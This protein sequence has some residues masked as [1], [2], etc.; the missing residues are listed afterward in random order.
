MFEVQF[1]RHAGMD[2]S[3]EADT[4]AEAMAIVAEEGHGSYLTVVLD[5]SGREVWT[6]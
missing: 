6:S 4:L 3:F 5:P 1:N 2:E